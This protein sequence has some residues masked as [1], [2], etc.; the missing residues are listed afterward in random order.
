[1]AEYR[2]GVDTTKYIVPRVVMIVI[3]EVL[4]IVFRDHFSDF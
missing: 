4:A 1:M 3:L 2:G